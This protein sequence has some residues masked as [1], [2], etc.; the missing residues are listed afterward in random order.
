MKPFV[1]FSFYECRKCYTKHHNRK[2]SVCEAD[3]CFSVMLNEQAA[4]GSRG[5]NAMET[6]VPWRGLASLGDAKKQAS[7]KQT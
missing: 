5:Q 1:H 3:I 2:T 7:A 4:C 6:K